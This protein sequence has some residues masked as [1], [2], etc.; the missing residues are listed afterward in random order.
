MRVV[1][2]MKCK[3]MAESLLFYTNV[4]D[5]EIMYPGTTAAE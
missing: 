3:D 5:Y 4:L 1:P 2:I